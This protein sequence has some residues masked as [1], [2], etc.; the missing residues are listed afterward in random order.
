[1]SREGSGLNEFSHR[2][3]KL[4]VYRP[5]FML[6]VHKSTLNAARCAS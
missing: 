5:A 3:A 1:V 2:V 4:S 6:A